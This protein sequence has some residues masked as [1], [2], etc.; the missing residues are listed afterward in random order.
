MEYIFPF[1]TCEKPNKDE[2]ISQPYSAIVNMATCLMIFYYLCKTS[3][4]YT[5]FFIFFI[6]CFELFH[7]I[8]HCIHIQGIIPYTSI[9]HCITYCINLAF[10]LALYN[11]TKKF[12][13]FLFIL[14]LIFIVLFDIYSLLN[15]SL[16]FYIMTQAILFTSIYFYYYSYLPK[17][18]QRIFYSIILIIIVG[19]IIE[20]NEIVNCKNMYLWNPDFPYHVF[21]EISVFI[22]FYIICSQF[23]KL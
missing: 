4:F 9:I 23:Y 19:L 5:V 15:I 14:F 13:S 6:L 22:L 16:I 2:Y 21:V 17:F 1:S 7:T 10:L 11:H 20:Y 12:P 18:L 8:S 3:H